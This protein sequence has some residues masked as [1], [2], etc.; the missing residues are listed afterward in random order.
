MEES[1]Q[2]R[3]YKSGSYNLAFV[4]SFDGN[5]S[6]VTGSVLHSKY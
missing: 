1:V 2:R 3:G 6:Y 4:K 5:E